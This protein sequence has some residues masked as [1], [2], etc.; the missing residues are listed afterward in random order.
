MR[1]K[2][3]LVEADKDGVGSM[4]RAAVAGDHTATHPMMDE[5]INLAS[6]PKHRQRGVS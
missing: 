2:A 1:F 5:R 6:H 4:L 3:R